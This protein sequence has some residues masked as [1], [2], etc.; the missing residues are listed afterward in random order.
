[1]K[2]RFEEVDQLENGTSSDKVI[3]I[4]SV[5]KDGK[6]TIQPAFDA[7]S[8][9]YAGVERLSEEDKK[10]RDYYI[11]VG[12]T[13]DEARHNTKLKLHNGYIFDLN[14]EVDRINWAWAKHLPCIA[15]SFKE[16]QMSKALFYVHIEGREA[17]ASN[18]LKEN[19]FKAMKYVM[20]GPQSN[21]VNRAL[22]LGL[23][24]EGEN[25]AVIKEFLLETAEKSPEKILHIFRDK[26]MKINLL[27]AQAKKMGIITESTTDGVVKYG[28]TILGVSPEAAIAFLQN[29][30]DLLELLER[31]VKPEYFEEKQDKRKLTPAEAAAKAREAKKKG[32]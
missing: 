16:A 25:P 4:R 20:E 12:K 3:E 22:L 23:D 2:N 6:H 31:D 13:G 17:E 11:T 19:K 1:M 29:N 9:W 15:M 32:K 14:K 18:S 8:G 7:S 26:G 21:W 27:Y 10:K 30:E 24:M 28:V 5:Y